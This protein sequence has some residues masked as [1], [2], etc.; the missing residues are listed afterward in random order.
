M[1]TS[2]VEVPWCQCPQIMLSCD[3]LRNDSQVLLFLVCDYVGEMLFDCGIMDRA[4]I[5]YDFQIIVQTER[6]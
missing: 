3:T 2:L 4:H 6:R 5:P 1:R